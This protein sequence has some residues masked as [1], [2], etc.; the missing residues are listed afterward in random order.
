MF[1]TKLSDELLPLSLF[2]VFDWKEN[3]GEHG[4]VLRLWVEFA[5]ENEKHVEMEYI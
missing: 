5:S 1:L 4:L 3:L 2:S